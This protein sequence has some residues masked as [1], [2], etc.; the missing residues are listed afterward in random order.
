[1]VLGQTVVFVAVMETVGVSD[2]FTVITTTLLL[3]VC[4]VTQVKLLVNTQF[5]VFPVTSEL[6]E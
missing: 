4:D 2:E 3:A 5:T 1:L 6:F